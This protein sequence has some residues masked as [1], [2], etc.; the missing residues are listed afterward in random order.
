[1]VTL[2]YIWKFEYQKLCKNMGKINLEAD[3]FGPI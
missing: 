2:K 1:M 3:D